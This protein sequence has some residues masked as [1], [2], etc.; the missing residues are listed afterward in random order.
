MIVMLI[1]EKKVLDL[2][3][4]AATEFSRLAMMHPADLHEFAHAIHLC[5]NIV[6]AREGQRSMGLP[7]EAISMAEAWKGWQTLTHG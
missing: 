2:L 6:L 3:G 7:A 5:Q 4:Q 1:D